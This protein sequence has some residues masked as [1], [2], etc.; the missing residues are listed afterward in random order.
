MGLLVSRIFG[1]LKFVIL[2]FVIG[3]IRLVLRYKRYG[4]IDKKREIF[5]L[6]FI[7]Y[8]IG[9]ASQ[10]I[11]PRYDFGILS[12]TGKIYLSVYFRDEKLWNL[13]P[14]RTIIDQLTGNINANPDEIMQVAVLNLSANL[15]LYCPLGFFL[16]VLWEKYKTFKKT[17][18]AGL[19]VSA[20]VEVIQF[21][22]GRSADIDDV[23][24]NVIGVAIG[25]LLYRFLKA[26]TVL[27]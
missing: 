12:D 17:L 9:M 15:L 23:F 27:R 22:I 10:T 19:C 14:F 16:P 25:Y 13:V 24:L 4:Q 5:M 1:M 11:L 18:L 21:F 8:I 26:V 20:A 3:G 2:G 7:A 6:L